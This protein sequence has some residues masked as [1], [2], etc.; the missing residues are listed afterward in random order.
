MA[1]RL[2]KMSL[3]SE[4]CKMLGIQLLSVCLFPGALLQSLASLLQGPKP[5]LYEGD[6]TFNPRTQWPIKQEEPSDSSESSTLRRPFLIQLA[7][8]VPEDK[9]AMEPQGFTR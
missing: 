8:P 4:S 3:Q 5:G 7:R 9:A 1:P 2:G 6:R